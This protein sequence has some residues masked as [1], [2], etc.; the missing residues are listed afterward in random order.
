MNRRRLA[1]FCAALVLATPLAFAQS[2][3]SRP[4]K[5]IV[6]FAAGGPADIYARVVGE[7]LQAAL[8]QP[9][10]VEDKPGGGSIVGTEAVHQSAPDGYTLLMMSNT[11]TVNESL[12]KEKPF[13][14]MR[15][16][17]PVA[18]VNYSDLV[19]VIHPSVPA[20]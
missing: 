17:V 14:L 16:F 9:F 5:I 7:K 6:P 12:I 11:H 13:E 10:V 3:P 18:P 4:V 2:Y 19:M 15:D 1:A 8:G 20:K